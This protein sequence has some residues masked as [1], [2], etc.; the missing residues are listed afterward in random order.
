MLD[1]I[2]FIIGCITCAGLGFHWGQKVE[3]N[4]PPTVTKAQWDAYLDIVE[5]ENA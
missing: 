5:A 3:R 4:R 2:I 1:T